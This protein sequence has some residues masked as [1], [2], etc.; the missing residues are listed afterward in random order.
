MLKIDKKAFDVFISAPKDMSNWRMNENSKLELSNKMFWL[1]EFHT[2]SKSF[3]FLYD[4]QNC[5]VAIGNTDMKKS[6]LS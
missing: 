5:N 2:V 1:N 6:I 3:T 4:H